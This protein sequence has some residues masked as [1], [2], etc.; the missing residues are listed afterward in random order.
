MTARFLVGTSGW[1]YPH[2][3]G[4][5]YPN[6]LPQRVWLAYYARHFPTVEINTTFYHLPASRTFVQWS[7][8]VTG[9]FTFAVKAS[10]YITHVKRLRLSRGQVRRLLVRARGLVR[11][12]GPILFQLPPNFGPD[13][14]R[15]ERFL[16]QL[17][18]GR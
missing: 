15:L 5:F 9:S 7:K 2:W 6:E 11:R 13:E 14:P 1:N 10:R 4:R 3:R 16:N 18:L 8:A 12:L 17:P